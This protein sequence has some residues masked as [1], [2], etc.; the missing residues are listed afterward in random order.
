MQSVYSTA[1]FLR[2]FYIYFKHVYFPNTAAHDSDLQRY[3]PIDS[4]GEIV[5]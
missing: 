3:K 5:M 4:C 2:L 1:S